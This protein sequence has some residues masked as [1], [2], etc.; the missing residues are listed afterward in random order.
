[1]SGQKLTDVLELT[2]T[3]DGLPSGATFEIGQWQAQKVLEQPLPKFNVDTVG[4]MRKRVGTQILQHH[5]E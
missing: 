3:G 4:R 1:L 5:I 2:H